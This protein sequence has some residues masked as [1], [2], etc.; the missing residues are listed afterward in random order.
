M[1]TNKLNHLFL[2]ILV[3]FPLSACR[4]GGTSADAAGPSATLVKLSQVQTGTLAESSDFNASLQSRKSVTLQPQVEGQITQIFV[5]SGDQVAAGTPIIQID[6]AEQAASVGSNVATIESAQADINAAQADT[7]TAR[8]DIDAARDTLRSLEAQR[9]SDLA[10]LEFNQAQYK[11]YA[12]LFAEGAIARQALDTYALQV[13]TAQAS[14]AKTSSDIRAQ[15]AT[16]AQKQSIVAQKQATVV[17]KQTVLQENQANTQQE[18]VKLQYY[19]ITAPFAGT[20]GEIPAKVGD[21]VTS[22]TSLFT[23]T[24]NQPLEV[25]VSIPIERAPQLRPG[26]PIELL[27]VQGKVVGTS[28]IFFIAPNVNN[29]TQSVL[30]KSLFDNSRNQLRADQLI[31]ARVIWDRRPGVLVPTVAVTNLAGENFVFVAETKGKSQLVAR[32]KPVDL[33]DIQGNNYQVLKGLQPGEKIVT[34]GIQKLS[35]G[36]PINPET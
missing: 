4:Q 21:F 9:R 32:Q 12:Q 13:K 6:P 5:R 15:Q 23:I 14:L 19:R 18:L 24:Q 35:D 17:Q 28:R 25:H 27:D 16:I 8:A 36:A 20:V 3:L 22:S 33:G 7:N 2:V 1:N 30:V 34:S 11:R 10:T 26:M 29:E 31:R